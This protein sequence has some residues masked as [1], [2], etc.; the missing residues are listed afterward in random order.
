V[1]PEEI[2]HSASLFELGASAD[3]SIRRS[4]SLL[5]ADLVIQEPMPTLGDC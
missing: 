1:A 2:I 5:D 4:Y 3:G